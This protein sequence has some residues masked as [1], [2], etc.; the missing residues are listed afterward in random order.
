M[1]SIS[2]T[3]K[4]RIERDAKSLATS[5]AL[6]EGLLTVGGYTLETLAH[7]GPGQYFVRKPKP[8]VDKKTGEVLVEGYR[9]DILA[10]TCS[11]PLFVRLSERAH[12]PGR[13][14]LQPNCKHLRAT[15]GALRDAYTLFAPFIGADLSRLLSIPQAGHTT[16]HA[17]HSAPLPKAQ[18][19]PRC[20][21]E[22]ISLATHGHPGDFVCSRCA[23]THNEAALVASAPLSPVPSQINPRTNPNPRTSETGFR[24]RGGRGVPVCKRCSV[25]MDAATSERTGQEGHRC[26]VCGD[27]LPL[28]SLRPIPP[29]SST[30]G[31]SALMS[32]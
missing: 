22:L 1:A 12:L 2:L 26:P 18:D 31:H 9:V 21:G 4:E 24:Q 32:Y 14:A 16:H 5:L 29:T 7:L 10:G 3:P 8:D 6:A 28:G 19:C 15:L 23:T 25:V 20:G 11:C 30:G 17:G 13:E 27:F